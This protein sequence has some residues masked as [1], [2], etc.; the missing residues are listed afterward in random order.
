QT[1]VDRQRPTLLLQAAAPPLVYTLTLHD[2]L[3]IYLVSAAPARSTG[4]T[5][6]GMLATGRR[7]DILLVDDTV[8]LRPQLIAVI[9]GGK[10]VHRSEEHA[11]ELQSPYD[12]VCRLLHATK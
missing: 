9:A 1:P 5:D 2:A 3:P 11:S 8:P 4:L 7:A 10:L 12:L 6:R